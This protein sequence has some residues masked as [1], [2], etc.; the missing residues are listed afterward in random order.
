MKSL[1]GY[2]LRR[3][4]GTPTSPKPSSNIDAGSGVVVVVVPVTKRLSLHG[5]L[6]IMPPE[7]FSVNATKMVPAGK[8]P[9]GKVIVPEV[10][11]EP[12]V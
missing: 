5:V 6:I 8:E 3:R 10:D 4:N 1:I 11:M 2:F 9:A 12:S 7:L